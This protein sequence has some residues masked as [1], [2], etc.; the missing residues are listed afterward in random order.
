MPVKTK[1]LLDWQFTLQKALFTHIHIWIYQRSA[2]SF[3]EEERNIFN[4]NSSLL[5]R[6]LRIY[7]STRTHILIAVL[8]G[9]RIRLSGVRAIATTFTECPGGLDTWLQ[10]RY[11]DTGRG[12]RAR[13]TAVSGCRRVFRSGLSLYAQLAQV[14]RSTREGVTERGEKGEGGSGSEMSPM[15]RRVYDLG[16]GL[17]FQPIGPMVFIRSPVDP[18]PSSLLPRTRYSCN[19]ITSG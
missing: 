15:T 6:V 19:E 1:Y 13:T 10:F 5:P 2:I 4:I 9:A 11:A 8:V 12:S 7:Q 16:I 14:A 18:L 3:L 17:H